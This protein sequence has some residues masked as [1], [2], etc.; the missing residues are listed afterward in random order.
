[1][2]SSRSA[3]VVSAKVGQSRQS[4]R[5]GRA[6]AARPT[7]DVPALGRRLRYFRRIK[8]LTLH[9]L[10]KGAACSA[11]L[12]SRI[13]NDRTTPSLTTLHRLC[14]ALEISVAALLTEAEEQPCVVYGPT[15]RPRQAGSGIVE[16]DGSTAESLVPFANVRLLEGFVISLA[17]NRKMCGPFEHDGEEVGYV[18]EGEL[19]LVVGGKSYTI[20]EGG[21]FF[22]RSDLPHSYGA[23]GR[24]C[25]RVIWINTPPTF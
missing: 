16:G 1:M 18:L 22:F 19:K 10:A 8:K 9:D 13:E 20:S 3:K 2:A 15:E 17:A 12:L 21:S 7:D 4:T 25:C 14:R 5:R 23:S 24:R 6:D 11:S